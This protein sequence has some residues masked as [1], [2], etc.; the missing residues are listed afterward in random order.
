MIML[1]KFFKIQ[2]LWCKWIKIEKETKV[3]KEKIVESEKTETSPEKKQEKKA[4]APITKIGAVLKNV[5]LEKGLK[6]QDVAK[7]LCIR[8]QYLDAIE[9]SNHQETPP[10][11]YG[12]GF[13]RS[14]AEFLG[15]NSSNIVELYKEE[16]NTKN[17]DSEINANYSSRSGMP[18]FVY[19]ILSLI[20]IALIYFAVSFWNN[21]DEIDNHPEQPKETIAENTDMIVINEIVEEQVISDNENNDT[22]LTN[23]QQIVFNEENYVSPET[24]DETENKVVDQPKEIEKEAEPKSEEDNKEQEVSNIPQKGIYI[25]VLEDTWVEVKNE[26]KLYLSK[27]LKAGDSYTLPNEKGLILSVGKQKG[28]NVYIDGVLSNLTRV[29]KKMNINIDNYI[30]NNH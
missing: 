28:V 10:F 18:S 14:Y 27:V 15:L 8:K 19:I 30:K 23:S 22:A 25:E 12:I 24:K 26:I 17:T 5:R 20:A 16:T 29:G 13:I 7:K 4:Q 6:L 3:K 2:I 11:P 21:S 1:L 9:E